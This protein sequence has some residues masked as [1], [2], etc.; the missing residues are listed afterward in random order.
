[1]SGGEVC[2]NGQQMIVIEQTDQPLY[3]A[4]PTTCNL[5]G[6]NGEV[7][8]YCW[9]GGEYTGFRIEPGQSCLAS[10]PLVPVIIN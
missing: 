3:T 7:R 8:E 1:M 6:E 2:P 5:Y 4:V 10:Q 9:C